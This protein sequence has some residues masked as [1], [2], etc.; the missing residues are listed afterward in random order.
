MIHLVIG[1]MLAA[2]AVKHIHKVITNHTTKHG[3][4][5]LGNAWTQGAAHVQKHTAKF[6]ANQA[7]QN[8]GVKFK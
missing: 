2:H 1:G 7:A 6:I 3:G 4:R 5:I 8:G